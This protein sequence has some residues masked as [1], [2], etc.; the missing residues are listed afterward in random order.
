MASNVLLTIAHFIRKVFYTFLDI[1][2]I[3][4][5]IFL[6]WLGYWTLS[7][8][9]VASW[10]GTMIL[11]LGIGALIIHVGHYFSL[12]ITRWLFGSGDYFIRK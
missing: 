10:L 6:A 5:G 4:L 2:G 7:G 11:I 8:H 1:S 3:L 9:V 12:K